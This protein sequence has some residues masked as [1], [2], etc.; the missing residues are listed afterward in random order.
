[1]IVFGDPDRFAFMLLITRSRKMQ[2]RAIG[3]IGL[4]RDAVAAR[5]PE[6]AFSDA[7]LGGP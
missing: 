1:M 6:S 3:D 2:R 4:L 7:W 5:I